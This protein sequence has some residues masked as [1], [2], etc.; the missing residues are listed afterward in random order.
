[1]SAQILYQTLLF[2]ALL[3]KNGKTEA[4]SCVVGRC[5]FY[6]FNKFYIPFVEHF[7]H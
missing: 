6:S 4:M 7:I 1:M 2:T 3:A 5:V